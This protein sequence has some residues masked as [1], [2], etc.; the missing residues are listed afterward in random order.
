MDH[1]HALT[2][3]MAEMLLEIM[4]IG[5]NIYLWAGYQ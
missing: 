4:M 5:L 2:N 3:Q 1:I